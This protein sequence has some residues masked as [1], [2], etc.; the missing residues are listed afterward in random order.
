MAGCGAALRVKSASLLA[1]P[2]VEEDGGVATMGGSGL[3]A[4]VAS[5]MHHAPVIRHE[6]LAVSFFD[7]APAC[8]ARC[9]FRGSAWP[10]LFSARN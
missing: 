5:I 4:T 9:D 2:A 3:P 6:H 10:P 7:D 8:S 1:E